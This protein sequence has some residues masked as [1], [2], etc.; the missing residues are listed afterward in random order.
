MFRAVS[1]FIRYQYSFYNL[2]DIIQILSTLRVKTSS[3][4][5]TLN[6]DIRGLEFKCEMILEDSIRL[7]ITDNQFICSF[8]R[9]PHLYGA[10]PFHPI[11]LTLK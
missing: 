5:T 10:F 7:F 8:P 4:S 2:K 3:I 6:E 1:N 9:L 11:V